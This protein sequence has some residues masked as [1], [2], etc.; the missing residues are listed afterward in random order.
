MGS[1]PFAYSLLCKMLIQETD[2]VKL[3]RQGTSFAEIANI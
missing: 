3:A 2:I 1:P